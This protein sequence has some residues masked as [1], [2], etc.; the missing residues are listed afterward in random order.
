MERMSRAEIVRAAVAIAEEYRLDDIGLTLRQLYYQ[1]VARGMV[2]PTQKEYKRIGAALTSARYSGEFPVSWISDRGRSLSH[3]DHFDDWTDVASA[4]TSARIIFDG[5]PDELIRRGRWFGQPAYVSVWVEKAALLGVFEP[6]TNALGVGLF[7]CRGYP[8]VSALHD[9]LLGASRSDAQVALV[10]YFGD[11][12]PD[13]WEIPRSAERN[14]HKLMSVY[15]EL[16]VDVRFIRVGLNRE[17][18]DRYGP[19]PFGAKVTS[20]RYRAYVA[21]H[22]TEDAW[23]LDA[24]EPRVLRRLIR[25]H[26]AACFDDAIHE[27]NNRTV[28]VLRDE[29]RVELNG[30]EW[31]Q[32]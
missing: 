23:E 20:A 8:S 5:L 25:E 22:Q 16:G 29:L 27:E 7:A 24:L 17:Q 26:V 18:V 15:P 14:L 2:S 28:S 12:D 30:D 4:L 6:V 32:P 19:P 3:C 11:F 21:E 13:G 9:W 1:F 10:L 31:R